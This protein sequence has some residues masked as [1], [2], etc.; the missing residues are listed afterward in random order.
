MLSKFAD[1]TKLGVARLLQTGE[2]DRK[3]PGEV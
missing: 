2:L 3:E 1:D